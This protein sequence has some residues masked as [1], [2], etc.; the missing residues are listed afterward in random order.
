MPHHLFHPTRQAWRWLQEPLFGFCVLGGLLFGLDHA[1]R[2]LGGGDSLIIPGAVREAASEQLSAALNRP[3][4]AQELD[5]RLKVWVNEEAIYREGLRLGLQQGDPEIRQRV[6]AK[7]ASVML[8]NLPRREPSDAEL[9]QWLDT[10]QARQDALPSLSVSLKHQG[11][12]R[13]FQH[14][15]EAELTQLYGTSFVPVVKALPPGQWTFISSS[16]GMVSTRLDADTARPAPD[17]EKL[18]GGLR[19]EWQRVE[20][21]HQLDLAV[22]RL[23]SH[24][25]VKT[26]SS[27]TAR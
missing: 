9:V 11:E 1:V 17:L 12:L 15:P 8:Q 19:L 18:R 20:E 2:V 5:A 23:V 3:P 24:Y 16:Q 6:L 27:E 4:S 13:V 25:A 22:A 10:V 14:V 21:R 26:E 7:T